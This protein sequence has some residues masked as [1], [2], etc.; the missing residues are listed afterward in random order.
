M[1]LLETED[2]SAS[3]S[4]RFITLKDALDEIGVGA[5]SYRMLLLCG[6]G[7]AVD[8]LEVNFLFFLTVCAGDSWNLSNTEM[9]SL[10]SSVFIGIL[11]GCA[12]WGD[13]STRIGRRWSY[14]TGS[15][16]IAAGGFL[17]GLAPNLASL[18]VF[19]TICGFGVVSI[20]KNFSLF[21]RH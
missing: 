14:I 3:S 19:R 7:F 13:I 11:I 21:F 15:G 10:N 1:A 4:T 9:A 6:L 16:L 17:T 8:S 12:F 18:I 2:T 20:V 5:F